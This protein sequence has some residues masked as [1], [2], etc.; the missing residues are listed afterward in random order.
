LNRSVLS[1][2]S[3]INWVKNGPAY[4]SLLFIIA[5]LSS[6]LSFLFGKNFYCGYICPYGALQEVCGCLS[7]KKKKLPG[8]ILNILRVTRRVYL[9]LIF[10]A[11][12]IFGN[13][14]LLYT[15]PFAVFL[16]QHVP[17]AFMILASIFL[18]ASFF[19]PRFWCNFFCPTGQIMELFSQRIFK[20]KKS[21]H[22]GNVK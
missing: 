2:V 15:E 7:F 3:I 20:P 10:M 17:L 4:V 8:K 13:I 1:L 18:A 14:G 5:A 21:P 19:I 16:P 12:L 9:F 22:P 6:V 11:I